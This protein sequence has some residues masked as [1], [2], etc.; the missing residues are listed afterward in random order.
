MT[1]KDELT[2]V[3]M[4]VF[5]WYTHTIWD[6]GS[7]SLSMYNVCVHIHVFR[8][9]CTCVYNSKFCMHIIFIIIMIINYFILNSILFPFHSCL[10]RERE[11]KWCGYDRR[12]W[13]ASF[14]KSSYFHWKQGNEKIRGNSISQHS[15]ISFDFSIL[16]AII[17]SIHLR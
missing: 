11:W 15:H 17:S 9:F 16:V 13:V 8:C 6:V 1:A 7:P 3:Y 5:K 10:R 14:S 2:K 4:F 12:L